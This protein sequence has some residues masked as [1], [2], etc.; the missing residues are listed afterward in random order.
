MRWIGAREDLSP[1]FVVDF[2]LGSNLVFFV[3]SFLWRNTQM[4]KCALTMQFER[5]ADG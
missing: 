2:S 5:Y 1:R 3:Q 4:F